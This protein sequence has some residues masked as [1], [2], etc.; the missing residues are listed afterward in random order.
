ML[1]FLVQSNVNNTEVDFE[2]AELNILLDAME[3]QRKTCSKNEKDDIETLYNKIKA[4]C[5]FDKLPDEQSIEQIK[6]IL[7]S[8]ENVT[9]DNIKI[10][11]NKSKFNLVGIAKKDFPNLPEYDEAATFTVKRADLITMFKKTIFSTQFFTMWETLKEF[12]TT[13][14]ISQ[15]A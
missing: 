5:I 4:L 11:A 12:L 7:L 8:T 2:S 9:K 6:N 10:V 1:K 15:D 13:V 14:Q 3:H